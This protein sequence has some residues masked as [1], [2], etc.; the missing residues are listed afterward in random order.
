MT[1]FVCN[2]RGGEADLVGCVDKERKEGMCC[3]RLDRE[4]WNARSCERWLRLARAGVADSPI[5]MLCLKTVD[6]DSLHFDST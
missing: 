2:W 3:G 4:L 6:A 5:H 1:S